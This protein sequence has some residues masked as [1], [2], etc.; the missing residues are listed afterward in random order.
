MH[1]YSDMSGDRRGTGWDRRRIARD[2]AALGLAR[3]E[4]VLV[5]CSLKSIGPLIEGPRTLF[6]AITDVIGPAGTVVVP[7]QT[8]YNSWTSPEF[9]KSTQGMSTQ[10]VAAYLDALPG[11]DAAT[12]P[13]R[14]MGAFAEYVRTRPMSC[15]STHPQT[16]FAA[17]GPAAADLT[18]RH[19]LACH[20]G[21]ES[22]L[23]RLHARGGR[24]VLLGVGFDRATAFHLAE[25]SLGKPLRPYHAKIKTPGS[26]R[27]AWVRFEAIELD[28]SGFGVLGEK[29]S[30]EPW[31]GS[32]PVGAATC[33]SFPIRPAVEFA[34]AL[35]PEPVNPRARAARD[36]R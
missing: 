35:G 11:F 25:Y 31:V 27:S 15:R 26:R 13:S 21:E 23:G 28:D 12:T 4:D 5:H 18:R 19:P 9:R 30:T 10:Q 32:G 22:P 16:S 33:F 24:A 2:L 8:A 29:M 7:T 17:F 34:R 3:G 1:Q 6:E 14:N 20:L 36:P